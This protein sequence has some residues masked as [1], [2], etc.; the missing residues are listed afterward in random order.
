MPKPCLSRTAT[1]PIM[2]TATFRLAAGGRYRW[3]AA[4]HP[5]YTVI[6]TAPN[7]LF[8]RCPPPELR[9]PLQTIELLR[10]SGG[11][12]PAVGP[13]GSDHSPA[14]TGQTGR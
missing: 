3:G 8:W 1:Q 13:H 5:D 14:G 6:T 11:I 2:S 10:G 12:L 4:F 7:Y 9:M